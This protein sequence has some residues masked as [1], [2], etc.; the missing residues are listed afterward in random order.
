LVD[1]LV[2]YE[3]S[4]QEA[5]ETL[6]KRLADAVIRIDAQRGKKIEAQPFVLSPQMARSLG[7]RTPKSAGGKQ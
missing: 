1:N 3:V 2:T 6:E 5:R 7:I 4:R